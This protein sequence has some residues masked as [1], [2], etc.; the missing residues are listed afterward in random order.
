MHPVAAG[1]PSPAEDHVEQELDLN[2]HLVP[3]PTAT[4]FVR[5]QGESM[6]DAGIHDGDLLVVDRSLDPQAGDVVIAAVAGELCVKRMQ[7]R[8]GE[9]QEALASDHPDFP[10]LA[11]DPETGCEIWGVVRASIRNHRTS[12]SRIR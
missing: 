9:G 12:A 3:R 4:Y 10:D 6:R 5:T 11:I 1:F 8:E 2:R 7:G